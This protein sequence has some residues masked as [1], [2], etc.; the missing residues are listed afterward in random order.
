M[1]KHNL[2]K[3]L[4]LILAFMLIISSSIST[5]YAFDFCD[6]EG[7]WANDLINKW[8]DKDLIKG[9]SDGTFR[10]NDKISRAEFV[11]LINSSLDFTEIENINFNDVNEND[12]FYKEIQ[13]AKKSG[14]INGISVTKFA[15]LK[16]ITREQAI[17]ILVRISKLE[18]NNNVDIFSDNNQISS[19]A[20][21]EIGAAAEVGFVEG[22]NDKTLRP[23]NNLSRA[24]ALKLIDNVVFSKNIIINGDN[25]T[26]KDNIIEGNVIVTQSLKE[27]NA[28]LENIEV[29]GS[30]IVNGG[31]TD[32]IHLKN[33]LANNI[34]VNKPTKVRVSLEENSN[35]KSVNING[36]CKL[37]ADKDS[38]VDKV[39]VNSE[40]TVVLSGK[41]RNIYVEKGSKL[42]LIGAQ[43]ESITVDDQLDIYLDSDSLVDLVTINKPTNIL[44]EGS[45][46][47]LEANTNGIVA[48]VDVEKVILGEG[49]TE[50]PVIPAPSTGGS[51]GGPSG[52]EDIPKPTEKIL[53][54]TYNIH[55]SDKIRNFSYVGD[56]TLISVYKDF[57]EQ[58]NNQEEIS[59]N[60]KKL[61]GLK[62]NGQNIWSLEMYDKIS[63]I[64][65]ID[66]RSDLYKNC[67]PS[68]FSQISID[69]VLKILNNLE[70]ITK[71]VKSNESQIQNNINNID[72]DNLTITKND[73]SLSDINV[74]FIAKLGNNQF[75]ETKLKELLNYILNNIDMLTGKIE[76][77]SF[78]KAILNISEPRTISITIEK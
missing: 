74:K 36:N 38:T 49:V 33:T 26:V 2:N 64:L 67:K 47:E 54:V 65:S 3:T 24:E 32:S 55:G 7:N 42:E 43:V 23:R 16:P 76:N 6:V 9:Y 44:G 35:V 51:A 53:K 73:S 27:G 37:E 4:S 22:Y 56:D 25:Q 30:I 13:I 63:T 71:H 62:I 29:K 14:Y 57:V 59:E 21:G 77:I 45:I 61:E 60:L 17:S 46:K 18:E 78:D 39:I 31:G 41:I 12:W 52:G 11:K 19:W 5:V 8:V 10:P 58:L 1:N 68:D 34:I 50:E 72:Y 66:K 15:P 48:E 70:S 20:I 75:D 28:Y 40:N 69:D